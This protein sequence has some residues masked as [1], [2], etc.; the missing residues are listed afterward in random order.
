M[1]VSLLR[2]RSE[3]DSRLPDTSSSPNQQQP[4]EWGTQEEGG[5]RE[6]DRE[7]YYSSQEDSDSSPSVEEEGEEISGEE[8]VRHTHYS[9]DSGCYMQYFLL[10]LAQ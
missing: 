5:E 4:L 6:E 1:L 2:S 7:I 9:S 3:E 10:P 8:Q